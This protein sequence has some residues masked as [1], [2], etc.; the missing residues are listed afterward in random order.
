MKKVLS[1]FLMLGAGGLIGWG[2]A[3][4]LLGARAPDKAPFLPDGY[5]IWLL[6]AL[7]LLYLFVVGLHELGHV[8]LG[9]LQNFQF[10]GLTIGPF[11]WKPDAEGKVRFHWNTSLNLAG[12]VAIMLPNGTK[13]LRQRFM[14]F[15]AGGPLASLLLAA[16]GYGLSFLFPAPAFLH[17]LSLAICLFSLAIFVATILP[18]RAGGFASDGLRILT[19]ARNGPTAAADLSSLRAAAHMRA[20][21]PHSELPVDEF[22]TVAANEKIPAQQRVTMEYYHY[23]HDVATGNIEAAAERYAG[24]MSRLDVYPA[25]THGA[26][27]LEQAL[28]EAH[29]QKDLPAAEAALDQYTESPF[30]EA[31]SVHLAEA[32]IAALKNDKKALEP[33]LPLIEAALPRSMDQSRVPLIKN[34]LKHW[35]ILVTTT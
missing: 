8:A 22:A 5:G 32:A 24:V 29:Y 13:Q 26:F 4:L 25:G 28:F 34:W 17:F 2:G 11:A 7:P 12:G 19:F 14:W 30:T 10:Y 21:L 1:L 9:R 27:Y 6:L 35:N 15:A 33:L 3:K 16:V 20:G 23:L 31:L 18:F